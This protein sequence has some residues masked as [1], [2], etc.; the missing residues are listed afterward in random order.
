M[1]VTNPI[2]IMEYRRM[3]SSD[4]YSYLKTGEKL[5][6]FE[7]KDESGTSFS[8]MDF[9]GKPL[10]LILF[11]ADCR[12]CRENFAYLEKN[13][14]TKDISSVNIIAFGR[15][16]DYMQINKYRSNYNLNFKLFTDPER[17]IY[18]KFAEKVVPRLYL[19]DSE[20]RLIVSVRGFRSMEMDG[21]INRIVL[22]KF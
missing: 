3:N 8:S 14:Y 10:L 6:E 19:F 1:G 13:L 16:C 20:S 21:I 2:A 18:S 15:E 9:C 4:E 12:H 7:W 22:N 5:P 17:I 11:A